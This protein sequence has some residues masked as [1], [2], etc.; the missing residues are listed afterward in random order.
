[1]RKNQKK[2]EQD[3]V[4]FDAVAPILPY[5][6]H[7]PLKGKGDKTVTHLTNTC[8]PFLIKDDVY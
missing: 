2:Q 3:A 8:R 4:V 5:P 6:G 1:M 7:T